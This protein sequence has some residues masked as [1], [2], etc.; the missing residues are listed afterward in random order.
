VEYA[1]R[2]GRS[3][4]LCLESPNGIESTA[5]GGNVFEALRSIRTELASRSMVICCNGARFDV[6]PSGLSASHGAWMVYVLRRWRPATVRDLVPIFGY[7]PPDRIGTVDE[8]DA[9]WERHLKNR[10]NWLNF[11]NP[12]WWIYLL[13][14]SWGEA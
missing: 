5:N 13:T 2:R 10:S 9:Y 3:W 11:I 12:V 1:D 4:S 6:R 14:A 7:A 8:R